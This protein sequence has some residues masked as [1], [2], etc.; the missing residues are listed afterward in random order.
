MVLFK[1]IKARGAINR[2]LAKN[3]RS[4]TFFTNSKIWVIVLKF[5][6]RPPE[7]KSF[8]SRAYNLLQIGR[9]YEWLEVWDL[10][11]I[12]NLNN[13]TLIQIYTFEEMLQ[14]IPLIGDTWFE[15]DVWELWI[16]NIK[17]LLFVNWVISASNCSKII[18]RPQIFVL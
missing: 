6:R 11:T 18:S 10:H 14:L 1:V 3:F 13:A 17:S 2:S 15:I 8:S 4:K 12:I 7:L 16:V 9:T 5:N